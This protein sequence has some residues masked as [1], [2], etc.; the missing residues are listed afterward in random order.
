MTKPPKNR[1]KTFTFLDVGVFSSDLN[2]T[3]L[4][5]YNFNLFR[6]SVIFWGFDAQCGGPVDAV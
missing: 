1:T 5:N 2:E 6:F 4:L 3:A